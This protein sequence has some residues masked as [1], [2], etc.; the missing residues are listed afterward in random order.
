MSANIEILRRIQ[1]LCLSIDSSSVVES[2]LIRTEKV[3]ISLWSTL[4]KAHFLSLKPFKSEPIYSTSLD[5]PYMHMQAVE[6][7]KLC[8]LWRFGLP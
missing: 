4:Q 8:D 6:Y 5:T 2:T 7:S 1:Y 3:E